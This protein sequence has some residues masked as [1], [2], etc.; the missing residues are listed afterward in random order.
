MS[1]GVAF[2]VSRLLLEAAFGNPAHTRL[3]ERWSW[4]LGDDDFEGGRNWAVLLVLLS[5]PFSF[6]VAIGL[7]FWLLS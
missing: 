6:A 2:H 5:V 3:T 1:F 4:H 7:L